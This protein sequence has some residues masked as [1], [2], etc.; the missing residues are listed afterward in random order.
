MDANIKILNFDKNFSKNMQNNYENTVDV[1]RTIIVS[2]TFFSINEANICYKI[3]KILYYSNYFSILEDYE[4]LNISQLNDVVLEKIKYNETV[5]Y[6]LFH[7]TDNGS[8]DFID[9]LYNFTSIKC[10]IFNI[11]NTFSNL[12]SG[13]HILYQNNICFFNISPNNILFLK[14]YREKP[15]LCNFYLSLRLNK[16]DFDYISNIL[17]KLDNYTYQ[18]LEVHIL[19]YI[20]KNDMKTISYSFIEEFTEC[21]IEKMSILRL[22]THKYKKVY[23]EK[24]V[25]QLKKY[26]NLSKKEIIEDILERNDKW[27][28]YGISML[29]IHVF[30]CI[31]RVF[32]LNN[33]FINKITLELTKNLHPDS[34]KR[35]SLEKTIFLFNKLLNEQEDW[36]F[37]NSLNN[38]KLK[39]LFDELSK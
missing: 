7:Y 34:E 22:F 11:I 13:L 16:L 17:H 8:I 20:I 3:K 1:N 4:P 23:K 35:R 36:S 25:E 37:I 10:L 9:Y 38:N 27:D 6:Y 18:P 32:S 14:N 12:F 33:S 31:S 5:Q 15:V 39:S 30:G 21:F 2:K 26:I 28:V 29:Y 24:C 19:F